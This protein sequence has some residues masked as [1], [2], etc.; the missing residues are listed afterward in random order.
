MDFDVFMHTI[1][2]LMQRNFNPFKSFEEFLLTF[3][4]FNGFW[5]WIFF[6]FLIFND[7]FKQC[8][9]IKIFMLHFL[10][11]DNFLLFCIVQCHLLVAYSTINIFSHIVCKTYS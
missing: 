8:Q 6:K 1:F 3:L 9:A 11:H 10:A 2:D 5:V 4:K 7:F